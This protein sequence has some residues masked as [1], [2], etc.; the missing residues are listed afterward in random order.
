MRHS[1]GS[2]GDR[3]FGFTLAGM[4]LA[5]PFTNKFVE[6][7]VAF[8]GL[9]KPYKKD[10]VEVPLVHPGGQLDDYL[11]RNW[12]IFPKEFKV[13]ALAVD[14]K[15]WM[16][17]TPMEIQS[18][19]VPIALAHG[20]V[21]TAGLGLGYF[22]LRAAG[23][24]EVEE[25]QV[26]E[27]E[28]RVVDFFMASFG[29]RPEM[30]KIKIVVGDARKE[31]LWKPSKRA[32]DYV[33]M[34]VYQTMLPDAVVDD[35]LLFNKKGAVEEY[36]FWGQ[37]RVVLDA[38]MAEEDVRIS[39]IY[40]AFFRAWQTTKDTSDPHNVFALQEMYAPITDASFREAVFEA[41]GDV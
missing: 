13:P 17:L 19:Y 32:F 3:R 4:L 20:V 34:D 9:P 23:M 31:M 27:R 11:N 29:D 40:E 22:A 28:P 26:F 41:I 1:L 2:A 25:V 38:H 21:G 35:I 12:R 33:F 15:L 14:K 37:E 6:E 10:G 8:Y 5:N 16:S 36:R 18:L 24:D 30:E 39:Y 7:E